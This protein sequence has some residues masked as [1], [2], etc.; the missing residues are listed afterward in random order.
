MCFGKGVR[1]FP[2]AQSTIFDN[3]YRGSLV[4]NPPDNAGDADSILGLG[5]LPWR[6][7]WQPTPVILPGESYGQSSLAGYSPWGCK[8]VGHT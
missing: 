2:S 3:L 6:R 4:K 1:G 7:K 8:T 5:R